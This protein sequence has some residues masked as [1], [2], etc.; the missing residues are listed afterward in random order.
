M[1][2]TFTTTSAPWMAQQPYLTRGFQRAES[3]Y[4]Q[5]PQ[6]YYPGQLVAPFGQDTQQAMQMYR[7]AA[8]TPGVPQ[9]ATQQAQD[10]LSGQY[11]GGN[12]YLDAMYDQAAS[13]V[14]R[15]YQ[16]AVAPTVAANFGLSGRTG[17]N[18]AFA[19]A[20]DSSRDTLSRNLSGMAAN[21]YG[22]AYE[23]ERDRQM[24][25]LG[26]APETAAL[27]YFGA[28]QLMNIGEMQDTKAQQGISADFNR[29]I[30]N[31]E[32]PW[33][34]L[35]RYMSTIQ[36]TYGGTQT[37]PIFEDTLGRNLGLAS[38]GIGLATELPGLF[39]SLGRLF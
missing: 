34:N 25:A 19:N 3:L 28:S 7:Q 8:Q 37:Q 9:A 33:D 4:G 5:G 30:F 21:L 12:P 38:M 15:N 10:T 16:E 39:D 20:M 31:Q 14:T 2:E 6:S 17:S 35:N 24:Q 11:L 36:G 13:A 18:M 27:P 26:M 22:P 1:P 32:A 23:A 29:Y